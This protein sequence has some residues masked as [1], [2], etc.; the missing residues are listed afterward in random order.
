M[1]VQL[2]NGI[3]EVPAGTLPQLGAA[4]AQRRR[5]TA[6]AVLALL[7]VAASYLGAL[8]GGFLLDDADNLASV[9]RYASGAA[10]ATGA[11]FSNESGPLGRPVAM[12]TF[13]AN[14]ALF[15]HDPAAYKAVN[16]V[17]HFACG[18]LLL[19]LTRRI[20][21]ALASTTPMAF[22]GATSVWWLVLPI[23]V[24][25][26]LY[27]VQRM[28]QLSALLVLVAA[29]VYMVARSAWPRGRR[30]DRW[31]LWAG[32]PALTL[33]AAFAKE[34]GILAIPLIAVIEWV[35]FDPRRHGK[36]PRQ[37]IAFFVL[38]LWMPL[39]AGVLAVALRPDLLLAGY[40]GRDF[41]LTER[42]LT[43]ARV[44]W[45]YVFASLVPNSP[46]LSLLHDNFPRSHG[47]LQPFTTLLAILGW[48][49]SIVIAWRLRWRLPWLALGVGIYL[50]GHALESTVVALEIYF[51]HRNYLP[52]IGLIWAVLG[53]GQ[54]AL[55]RLPMPSA[56]FARFVRVLPV[57]VFLA[58][59]VPMHARARIWSNFDA[60]LEQS[61]Q[62]NPASVRL[63]TMLAGRA[64]ERADLDAA[65]LHLD[66][67]ATTDPLRTTATIG[68]WRALA[69]CEARTHPPADLLRGSKQLPA[70]AIGPGE[71]R[72]LELVANR[73]EAGECPG[74]S[75]SEVAAVAEAWLEQTIQPESKAE[76]WRTRY[77]LARMHGSQARWPEAID[78]AQAA[79]SATAQANVGVGVL[80]FQLQASAGR[81][82]DARRTLEQLALLDDGR[83]L[84]LAEA[85]PRLRAAVDEH[86]SGKQEE[87]P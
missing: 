56:G 36:R 66:A 21:V 82:G 87:P 38:A 28:T 39:L 77:F 73:V 68:L 27:V 78:A 15:G 54:Q 9:E 7:A 18:L 47:L 83:D 61:L 32:V 67:A 50:V 69:Y 51:E 65:L 23:H 79:F 41:D 6:L 60:L 24:S 4:A 2:G 49:A 29:W 52:A 37:V 34:N 84:R 26:V 11:I 20:A 72:A 35:V 53:C 40:V 57:L 71:S 45:D 14:A 3:A 85:L 81:W 13:V 48:L 1:G 80:L 10:S 75:A 30:I 5:A 22:A 33:L 44:L 43:E 55:Q 17:L 12:A 46:S 59:L 42:V 74:L 58:Y 31:L 16:V 8:G 76:V 64:I 25:T 19:L 62:S 70:R 86:T 63:R